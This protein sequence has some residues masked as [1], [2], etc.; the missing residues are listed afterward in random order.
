[1]PYPITIT[2]RFKRL[3]R[4]LGRNG[5]FNSSGVELYRTSHEE[6]DRAAIWLTPLTG[7]GACA[8]CVVE[9]PVESAAKVGR[10]LI[11][12]AEGSPYVEKEALEE[13]EV[14]LEGGY[15]TEGGDRDE[16]LRTTD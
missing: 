7:R 3:M 13:G 9:L 14:V 8:R 4:S 15:T 16:R 2:V 10:A 1:M 11:A 12:L 5:H 6:R